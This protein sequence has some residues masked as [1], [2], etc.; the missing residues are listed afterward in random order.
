MSIDAAL[1][2]LRSRFHR[3]QNASPNPYR[4]TVT[5][6]LFLD[7]LRL[8]AVDRQSDTAPSIAQDVDWTYLLELAYQEGMAPLIYDTLLQSPFR[9]I[10][11]VPRFHYM[12]RVARSRNNGAY[13]QL[14]EVL[15]SLQSEGIE[16]IILKGAALAKQVYRD[17][18]L[19]PFKDIDILVRKRDLNRAHAKLRNLGYQITWKGYPIP[20]PSDTDLRYRAARQ[21][22]HTEKSLLSIDLYWQLIRYPFIVPIDHSGLWDRASTVKIGDI[23]A[24]AL[25][26]EDTIFHL[27]LDFTMDLWY[28]QPELRSLRDIAEITRCQEVD[29]DALVSRTHE[30]LIPSLY[31]T[32]K[33]AKDLLGAAIPAE[34]L[35]RIYPGAGWWENLLGNHLRKN[36]LNARHPMKYV[37][38][39]VLM[40]L[41]G[42]EGYRGKATWLTQLLI[43][44]RGLWDGIPRVLSRTLMPHR[45]S[46]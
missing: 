1:T 7:L 16:A 24:R 42:P 2:G 41:F 23:N 34:A 4:R 15:R 40:R 12:Y 38:L 29:W 13:V 20:V 9:S 25:S 30:A 28:G 37:I 39:I 44:P 5:K 22:F 32:C 3:P 18:G 17:P 26:P 6:K 19:R 11:Q 14:Q 45:T 36:I 43:P 21:Y 46:K 33:L 8:D 27:S 31:Y 35:L 10:S